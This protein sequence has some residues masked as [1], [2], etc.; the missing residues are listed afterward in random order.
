MTDETISV[1]ISKEF[2][3]I[4]QSKIKNPQIGFDTVEEYVN[5]VLKEVLSEDNIDEST[6]EVSEEESQKIKEELK[7]MG[8][9]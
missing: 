5:Y 4:I 7:K 1:P 2:F 9:I 8:Y 3:N 6:D